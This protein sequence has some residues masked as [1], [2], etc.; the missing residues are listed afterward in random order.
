[1]I[2]PSTDP[3]GIESVEAMAEVGFD[4]A[5]L[6]LRDMAALSG[7]AFDE[8]AGR[9]ERSGI[10]CEACN[11]LFPPEIRLTGPP[12]HPGRAVEYAE[13]AMDRAARLGAKVIVFGSSGARNVPEGFA[14]E[15][16]WEQLSEL[17]R[18]LAPL[19]AERDVTL[20]IEHL[21]RG[22]SNIVNRV[23]DALQLAREVDH[24]AV[25]ILIDFYHLELENEDARIIAEAGPRVRHVHLA[26]VEG[27]QFPRGHS[28]CAALFEGLARAGYSGRCSIEAYSQD[29][30]ADARRALGTL[31]E[32][33]RTPM[34]PHA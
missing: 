19:A 24:P 29:F 2:S 30:R 26:R 31:R 11:N 7:R 32:S 33:A 17:L 18:R 1:M 15:A 9:V 4:Y 22:E 21:T 14:M 6:S 28:D 3:I 12:A 20:A 8:L 13:A 27:R 16:A 10:Q 23:S 34:A 5:E 25:Q